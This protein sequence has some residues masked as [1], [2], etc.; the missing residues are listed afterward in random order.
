MFERY[1]NK[2]KKPFK[3]LL[4]VIFVLLI[5]L[6]FLIILL[7]KNNNKIKSINQILKEIKLELNEANKQLNIYQGMMI[8]A[9]VKYN[10]Y[11]SKLRE[12]YRA[13]YNLTKYQKRY[14]YFMNPVENEEEAFTVGSNSE[15]GKRNI[16]PYYHQGTDLRVIGKIINPANGIVYKIGENKDA[17][18]YLVIYYNIQG[19]EHLIAFYHC[20]QRLVK[21]GERVIVG[22]ELAKYGST[23]NSS[24]PHNHFALYT[25]IDGIWYSENFYMDSFHKNWCNDRYKA[26]PFVYEL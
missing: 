5:F 15:Y 16:Y 14:Y 11:Y 12:K 21:K 7:V 4:I 2:R 19:R 9:D 18:K 6:V 24:G 8:E 26:W 1:I 17:G 13:N 23:G 3:S 10:S 22:Q 20:N 25:K